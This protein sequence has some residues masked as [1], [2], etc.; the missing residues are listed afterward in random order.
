[1][2][3]PV[4]IPPEHVSNFHESLIYLPTPFFFSAHRAAHPTQPSPPATRRARATL[5]ANRKSVILAN[6]NR[7]DKFDKKSFS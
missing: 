7:I 6:F 1:M 5:G 4:V 3:D 2:F